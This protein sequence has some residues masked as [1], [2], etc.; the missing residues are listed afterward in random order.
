MTTLVTVFPPADIE[1]IKRLM[2]RAQLTVAVAESLTCGQLQHLLGSVSGASS[3]FEGGI[4][5]YSLRQKIALLGLE[6]ELVHHSSGVSA[7]IAIEMASAVLRQFD[8]HLAI[9]TTGYAEADPASG[10]A[11][12]F[13]HFAIVSRDHREAP[14]ALICQKRVIGTALTRTQMHSYVCCAAL[15]QLSLY[16]KLRVLKEPVLH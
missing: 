10:I 1:K 3:Y 6:E 7:K 11:A 5:A 12:P 9:A 15:T 14:P 4:T 8:T 2:N 13:A 16:L